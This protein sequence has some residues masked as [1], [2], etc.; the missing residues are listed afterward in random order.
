MDIINNIPK[1][2][3]PPLPQEFKIIKSQEPQDIYQNPN[4][5]LS[6]KMLVNEINR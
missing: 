4:N 3:P 5:N 2:P 6:P 1:N